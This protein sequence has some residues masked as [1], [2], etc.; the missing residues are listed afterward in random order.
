MDPPSLV[1]IAKDP[2]R[3]VYDKYYCMVGNT[4]TILT[5]LLVTKHIIFS[6]GCVI[7][8]RNGTGEFR[9]G[10]VMKESFVILWSCII[11]TYILHFLGIG[12]N[13]TYILRT[14]FMSMGLTMF[15]GRLLISRCYRHLF[16]EYI[17]MIF[18]YMYTNIKKLLYFSNKKDESVFIITNDTQH[19]DN[20]LLISLHDPK[21][22]KGL[23]ASS[24]LTQKVASLPGE[25][26]QSAES[27][28]TGVFGTLMQLT[29][30]DALHREEIE[31][32]SSRSSGTSSRLANAV[33]DLLPTSEFIQRISVEWPNIIDNTNKKIR[34]ITKRSFRFSMDSPLYAKIEPNKILLNEMYKVIH[35][36]DDLK[37]FRNIAEK[38][39]LV[40]NLDFILAIDNYRNNS[41][42]YLVEFSK[43]INKN[44]KQDAYDCFK[45][46]I[47]INSEL[48]V[49]IS[50]SVRSRIVDQL[51]NWKDNNEFCS[52]ETIQSIL[53]EEEHHYIHI[54]EKA[55]NE[56]SV[57]LYQ[58]IW[59]KYLTE[60]IKNSMC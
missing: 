17:D 21:F 33:G 44:M 43:Q 9:D 25:F 11:I 10:T 24:L 40:E 3:P 48:E 26:G 42:K 58:N 23:P 19:Y 50:S 45:K 38:S 6:V 52:L 28:R 13:R 27:T 15:C 41:K 2:Y 22:G 53:D 59:N 7:N 54:F 37:K 16:P 47:E 1:K 30:K 31:M 20:G 8:I 51:K 32:N 49:N 12:T 29:C 14:G 34:N 57:M 36:E 4:S 56:I 46:F 55:Y 60:E 35:N 39:L 5:Y 18:K